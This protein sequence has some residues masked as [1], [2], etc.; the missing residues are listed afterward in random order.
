MREWN[1]LRETEGERF[2]VGKKAIIFKEN[3]HTQKMKSR[4]GNLFDV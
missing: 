3:L 2:V 4:R 1:V